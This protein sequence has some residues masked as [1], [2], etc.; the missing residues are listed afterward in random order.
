MCSRPFADVVEMNETLIANWNALVTKRD[1]V[2][3]LGDFLYKGNVTQAN[4]IL[5][6]LHGKKHL[7]KGNHEKYLNASDFDMSAFEWIKDFFVLDYKDARYV[8][9][10]YPIWEWPH[11]YRK[12]VHLYGHVHKN[13]S[14]ATEHTTDFGIFN[15]RAINVSVDQNGYYPVSADAIYARAFTH[16]NDNNEEDVEEP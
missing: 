4:E 13:I 2:Y 9:F 6:R 3:V 16:Y 12:S 7:I 11:Y 14:Q 10:H 8:L 1:E 5:K 15:E